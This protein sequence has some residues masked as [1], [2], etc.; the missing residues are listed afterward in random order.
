MLERVQPEQN[1]GNMPGLSFDMTEE[2]WEKQKARDFNASSG[3]LTEGDTYDCKVCKNKGWV[4]SAYQMPNG[5]WST[6]ADQCKCMS[7]RATIKRME[8]SG[9]KNIIRDY[10]W[11]KY[12]TPEPWQADLKAKTMAYSRDPHGWLFV[13]GQPGSGKTH[14]CTAVCRDFLLTGREVKYMMWMDD[15]VKIKNA[16]TDYTER[17]SLINQYKNADILYIDD[18]FKTERNEDGTHGNPTGA[19]IR[20]AFEILNARYNRPDALTIISTEY[21]LD[22]IIELDE[23]LGSR[24][25]ERAG[26]KIA[27]KRDRTRNYRLKGMME[28]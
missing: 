25:F 21:H 10:T 14:C 24:I 20:T 7:T 17:E 8:K 13:G 19:D 1:L 3:D 23:A 4:M 15:V 16:A 11:D 22:E 2:E 26:T 9:L 27:V 12:E 5:H 18:L 28:I 6:Q